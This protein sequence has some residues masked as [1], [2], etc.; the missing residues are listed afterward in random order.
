MSRQTK[1]GDNKLI[2]RNSSY[3]F[4]SYDIWWFSKKYLKKCL[5]KPGKFFQETLWVITRFLEIFSRIWQYGLRH[6]PAPSL[7]LVE[8]PYTEF[9][10]SR[11]RQRCHL[12]L[13]HSGYVWILTLVN[14]RS[15]SITTSILIC[16]NS[17][18]VL[19]FVTYLYSLRLFR[20]WYSYFSRILAVVFAGIEMSVW[21]L[22][23]SL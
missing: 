2:K 18:K 14:F 19:S 9:S 4:P 10:I 8:V 3:C 6:P 5:E 21:K 1:E 12:Y 15:S 22:F 17:L 23:V 16:L 20:S 7:Y 13:G 11:G